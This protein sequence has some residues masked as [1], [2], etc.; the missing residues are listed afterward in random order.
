MEVGER[1]RRVSRDSAPPKARRS[2]FGDAMNGKTNEER[3][4]RILSVASSTLQ[5]NRQRV[6][7]SSPRLDSG[8]RQ[9]FVDLLKNERR[10]FSH[11]DRSP[12]LWRK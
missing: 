2:T 8:R 3:D 9:L 6:G 5:G 1:K 7:T 10:L 11:A 4:E 12:P